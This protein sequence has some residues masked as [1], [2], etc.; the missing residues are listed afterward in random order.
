M[1]TSK[2][3]AE[4]SRVAR[5]A[6]GKVESKV[7]KESAKARLEYRKPTKVVLRHE[8]RRRAEGNNFKGH[9][10]MCRRWESRTTR[11]SLLGMGRRFVDC[12][13][14][15]AAGSGDVKRESCTL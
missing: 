2:E 14:M 15:L 11:V 13:S 1:A 7:H 8:E 3:S 4:I 9:G 12:M 6:S 5:Q 10:E